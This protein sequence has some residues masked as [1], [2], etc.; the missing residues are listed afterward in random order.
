MPL[1]GVLAA[2]LLGSVALAVWDGGNDANALLAAN[3]PATPAPMPP[4]APMPAPRSPTSATEAALPDV[5]LQPDL[6]RLFEQLLGEARSRDKASLLK[7]LRGKLIERLPPGW[8]ERALGLLDRYIDM[9]AAMASIARPDPNDPDALRRAMDIRDELRR[10]YFTAEEVEGLFGA[11]MRLDRFA[12]DKMD[13]LRDERLEAAQKQ[14]AIAKLEQTHHLSTEQRQWR[15]EA[16]LA[17]Q[18]GRQTEALIE[19]GAT[20]QER[21][22]Q[23][24]RVHGPQAAL[25]LAELDEQETSWQQR[26]DQYAHAG[27]EQQARMRD[28]LFS[29]EEQ[30]RLTGALELRAANRKQQEA[31]V[32]D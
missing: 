31:R 7:E 10:R 6:L 28:Q 26:L 23:R 29:P 17:D 16:T 24:A 32:R 2:L 8:H 14:E 5:L 12:L 19:H 3:Q 13:I 9:R 15:Q 30:L 20:P 1:W 18:V 4:P 27:A 25:R 22:A 21:F 11:D